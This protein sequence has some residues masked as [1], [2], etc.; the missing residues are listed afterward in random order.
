MP[1]ARRRQPARLGPLA[2]TTLPIDRDRV[3]AALG[4]AG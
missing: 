2:G 3:A 1:R 4:F